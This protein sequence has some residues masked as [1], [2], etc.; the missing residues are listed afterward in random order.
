MEMLT[1][2]NFFFLNEELQVALLRPD[3]L[4]MC[5]GPNSP[6]AVSS[7]SIFQKPHKDVIRKQPLCSLTFT[8]S[9]SNVG[10]MPS[11]IVMLATV[12]FLSHPLQGIS[13]TGQQLCGWKPSAFST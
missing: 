9:M 5:L 2:E 10:M 1:F 6:V 11:G 12:D 3:F 13:F 4:A 8:V 7:L